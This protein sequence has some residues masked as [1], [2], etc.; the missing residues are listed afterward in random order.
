MNQKNALN[1]IADELKG[2]YTR[3]KEQVYDQVEDLLEGLTGLPSHRRIVVAIAHN[4]PLP[5][6]WIDQLQ[7][8]IGRRIGSVWVHF[9]SEYDIQHYAGQGLLLYDHAPSLQKSAVDYLTSTSN[10]SQ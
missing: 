9:G 3:M 1:K 6:A 4:K 10:R 5:Q 8:E 7:Q 2:R